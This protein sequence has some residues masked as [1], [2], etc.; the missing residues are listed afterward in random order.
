MQR[1]AITVVLLIFGVSLFAFAGD[2]ESDNKLINAAKEGSV[3]LVREFLAKGADINAKDSQGYTPLM[4]AAY[5]GHLDM[6]KALLHS[7]AD[8]NRQ[9]NQ[10][11]TAL[12]WAD[13]QGHS[14]IVQLLKK[15][16]RIAQLPDKSTEWDIYS[17]AKGYSVKKPAEWN[18]TNDP[19]TGR[20]VIQG[21][22]GERAVIWPMFIEQQRLDG[23]GASVVIQQIAH[24]VDPQ[25][26]WGAA[27]V[28]GKTVCV[29]ARL[30]ERIGA[31]IMTWETVQ[32]GTSIFIYSLTAP[33]DIY[34]GSVDI[35]STILSSFHT[36]KKQTE[37]SPGGTAEAAAK[38]SSASF[39]NWSD[40]HEGA[41]SLSVPQEWKVTGGAYRLSAT[42]VRMSVI[43]VSSDGRIRVSAG[44][45]K[46]GT[47]TQPNQMYDRA[48]L[49][50]GAM[51]RLGDGTPLQI[52][53]L[54]SGQQFAREYVEGIVRITCPDLRI[55]SNSLRL[56]LT[57]VFQ[58]QARAEGM[59]NCKLSAG[60]ASFAGSLNG[61]EVRGSYVAA[62]CLPLPDKSQLWYVYRLYG[63]LA[64][65]ER[66]QEADMICRHVVDSWVVN[67][68][69]RMKEKQMAASAVQA[70]NARSRQIQQRALQAIAEDQRETSDMISKSYWQRQKVYSEISRK[71]ENAILGT[72]DVVDPDSHSQYKISYNSD[73][74]WMDNQGNIVG[75]RTDTSPGV[76]WRK[77]IDLP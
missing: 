50:E 32:N 61:N 17:D 70:D 71:R 69:W 76:G 10:G 39:V 37:N 64:P 12:M 7:G 54:I 48:G 1:A 72:V 77:M 41:F 53:T 34:H 16:D 75:T 56:D 59:M 33:P 38:A 42:D 65:P 29:V 31:T 28:S 30:P 14:D 24:K 15:T 20:I 49:K 3:Q 73:Y 46:V 68:Q 62:T 52:R 63:Y 57:G 18:V 58:Q 23:C 40:P 5:N 2:P 22:R 60:E 4:W 19:Q 26:P 66:Q 11:Y 67:P 51:T 36:V 9:D 74:N 47:F 25:L 27:E 21:K 8:A 45:S 13:D 44:D 43:L 55:L 6:V 35:F